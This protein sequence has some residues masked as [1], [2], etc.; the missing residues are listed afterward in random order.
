MVVNSRFRARIEDG[1]KFNI[2]V[3]ILAAAVTGELLKVIK[4]LY[5]SSAYAKI[6]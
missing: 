1:K 2:P 5:S 3:K 4:Y 6:Y